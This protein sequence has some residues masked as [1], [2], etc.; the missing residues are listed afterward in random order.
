MKR[1]ETAAYLTKSRQSLT[2]ARVVLASGL[3][4][5]AGRAAYLA[6]FHA[7]QAL[8]FDRTGKAAK[9]H[10][11]VRSEFARLAKDDAR[12]ERGFVSFLARAYSLKEAADYAIGHD[13]RVSAEA[14]QAIEIAARFVEAI[15]RLLS[16]DDEA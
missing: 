8:I 14:A 15:A 16:T 4:E 6:A 1:P 10:G 5:A 3:T 9:T 2:E 11:G 13:A 7:A 12:I